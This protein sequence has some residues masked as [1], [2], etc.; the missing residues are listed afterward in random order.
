MSTGLIILLFT[1]LGLTLLVLFVGLI[2][3][4]RGGEFN[5]KYANKLMRLRVLLQAI[6]IAIF[7]FVLYKSKYG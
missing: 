2:S 7:A 6:A 5:K 4:V 1:A 3:M